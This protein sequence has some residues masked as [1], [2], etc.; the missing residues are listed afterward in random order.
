LRECF[1]KQELNQQLGVQ[2]SIENFG[3]GYS[4]LSYL[5]RFP[6]Q[7]INID[8]SFIKDLES[9]HD[10]AAI[11]IAMA[12]VQLG[13]TLG[14]SVIAEGVETLNRLQRLQQMKCDIFQ[15]FYF[16]KPID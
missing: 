9:D 3:T 5:Q 11:A 6:V 12:I 1:G 15:G 2:V 16:T 13:H 8:R 14:M 4:S 7:K 10:D